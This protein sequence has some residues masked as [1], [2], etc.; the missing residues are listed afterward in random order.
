MEQDPLNSTELAFMNYEFN[1]TTHELKRRIPSIDAIHSRRLTYILF[2]TRRA[3]Y[4]AAKIKR[5]LKSFYIEFGINKDT[6]YDWQLKWY[7]LL[8]SNV[9][10]LLK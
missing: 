10:I 6:Y 2:E 1:R 9:K 4:N 7:H 3:A 5:T 8:P